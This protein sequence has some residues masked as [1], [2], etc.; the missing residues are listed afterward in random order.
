ME[1]LLSSKISVEQAEKDE[2]IAVKKALF[3][4]EKKQ[5]LEVGEK[6]SV[7]LNECARAFAITEYSRKK[8]LSDEESRAISLYAESYDLVASQI[9]ENLGF[10]VGGRGG[11]GDPI[12]SVVTYSS[13]IHHKGRDGITEGKKVVVVRAGIF[14]G[15]TGK[16]IVYPEVDDRLS[17][18]EEN[19]KKLLKNVL[20][21]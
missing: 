15:E 17:Y 3:E 20:N 8:D 14:D 18:V 12:G 2:E 16:L 11:F 6:L 21:K 7:L 13:S 5:R 19:L 10:F 9:E 1:G 4:Q